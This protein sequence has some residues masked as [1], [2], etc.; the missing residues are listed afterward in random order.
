MGCWLHVTLYCAG[1]NNPDHQGYY[2]F[3]NAHTY[4]LSKSADTSKTFFA[5]YIDSLVNQGANDPSH[6]FY[7]IFENAHKYALNNHNKI[8]QKNETKPSSI[9]EQE[10][11]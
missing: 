8:S 2:L 7:Y 9:Q 3:S 6:K 1:A 10:K 5:H 4:A 11:Q